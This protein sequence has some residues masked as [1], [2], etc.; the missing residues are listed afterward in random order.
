MS[1]PPPARLPRRPLWETLAIFLA[2]ASLWPAYIL[3]LHHPAW[4]WVCYLMLPLMVVIAV[5][6]LSRFKENP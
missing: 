3:N 6:R 5:R 1:D 2:I 4:K